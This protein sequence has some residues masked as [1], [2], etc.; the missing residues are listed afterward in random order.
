M[1]GPVGLPEVRGADGTEAGLLGGVLRTGLDAYA[2]VR[3]VRC[4]PAST[5]RSRPSRRDRLRDRP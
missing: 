5:R 4:C 1:K 2:N 3:P